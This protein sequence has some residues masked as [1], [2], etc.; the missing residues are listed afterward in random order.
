MHSE[1]EQLIRYWY[2]GAT[3]AWTTARW[4]HRGKRY[5]DC[6][7]FCQLALEK[8]L[9]GLVVLATGKQVPYLHDLVRLAKCARVDMGDA[10]ERMLGIISGFNMKARYDDQKETFWKQATRAY[11]EEYLAEADALRVWLQKKYPSEYVGS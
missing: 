7:F 2:R 11:T 3:E 1:V 5:A 4:L 6:L 8:L 10:Q 9:K